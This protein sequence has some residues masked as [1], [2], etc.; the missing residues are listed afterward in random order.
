MWRRFKAWA[1]EPLPVA[2]PADARDYALEARVEGAARVMR[3]FMAGQSL[4]EVEERND[5]AADVLLEVMVELGLAPKAPRSSVPV[6]P[7][8]SS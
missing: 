1:T 3:A 7:G 5:E 2:L 4:L 8:R 6:I